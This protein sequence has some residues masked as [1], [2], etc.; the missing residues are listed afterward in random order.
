MVITFFNQKGGVGK[1]TSSV[2]LTD[3]FVNQNK[4][5]LAVDLD[6]QSSFSTIL[7]GYDS[8]RISLY[9]YFVGQF[10]SP[11]NCITKISENLSILPSSVAMF[12]LPE[13]DST[14]LI[15]IKILFDLIFK[16]YDVVVI[17]APPSLGMFSRLSLLLSDQVLIPV[18]STQIVYDTLPDALMTIDNISLLNSK[19]KNYI[20]FE[21]QFTKRKQSSREL[22]RDQYAKDNKEHWFSHAMPQNSLIE[23]RMM[24]TQNFFEFAPHKQKSDVQSFFESLKER[25]HV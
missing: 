1:T 14:E 24:D 12:N 7:C 22:I 5:V 15:K 16:D 11:R 18:Q 13:K 23:E 21:N 20:I 2:L 8:K 17:D 19:L 6:P 3:Y 4:K 9:H 10:Q 25:I